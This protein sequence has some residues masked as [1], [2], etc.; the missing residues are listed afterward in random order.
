[1]VAVI[2]SGVLNDHVELTGQVSGDSIDIVN[3]P[4]AITD[5]DGHGTFVSGIIA[6]LKN[7]VGFHGIA[8]NSTIL[9]IRANDRTA[10]NPDVDDCGEPDGGCQ[11]NDNDL[12]A[13]VN[14]AIDNGA[15]IINLSLGGGKANNAALDAALARAVQAGIIL[16]ASAGN[17]FEDTDGDGQ[18]DDPGALSPD[19]PANFA[20]TAGALGRALAV[21]ATDQNNLIAS[22][23]NRAG[24]GNVRNFYLVAPGVDI[25]TS[26][27]DPDNPADR[28]TLFRVSGT[29]FSSPY[30]AG[31]LALLLEAF[32]NLEAEEAVALLIDTAQDL[33][34]VGVDNT[35]GAG[36]VDLEAAFAPV[37]AT[38]TSFKG[39]RVKIDLTDL[40]N[41][42]RGAFGDWA[43][44][45]GAF[46]DLVFQDKYRRNFNAGYVG[47]V[48]ALARGAGL[49]QSYADRQDDR[50]SSGVFNIDGFGTK[51]FANYSF[52]EDLDWRDHTLDS[53]LLGLA[54]QRT[55]SSDLEVNMHFGALH[56]GAGRG[57]SAP[58]SGSLGPSF[59]TNGGTAS[60]VGEPNWVYGGF[61]IS[62]NVTLGI[63]TNSGDN[64]TLN[65]F[66][67]ER[68]FGRHAL[69]GEI[70]FIA[71]KDRFF[72]ANLLSRFGENDGADTT[73]YAL[74]WQ[75]PVFG[76]WFGEG[77][78]ELAQGKFDAP[79]FI[80]VNEEPLSSSWAFSLRRS[81]FGRGT[82]NLSVSQPL[83]A[84][85]GS[86]TLGVP[87][88]FDTKTSQISY[89]DRILA[90]TPSGRELDIKGSFYMPLDYGFSLATWAQY[91]R[92]PQHFA[93]AKDEQIGWVSLRGRF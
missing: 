70:G 1:V 58:H 49:L 21:G 32:P 35:F 84:E 66:N 17:G 30:V 28:N 91:V 82:F 22:F 93:T 10:S 54:E 80:T 51:G 38:T 13:A 52:N 85:T 8:F 64:G 59:T 40:L 41:A 25:I 71:E 61:D 2:D 11:F 73:Y 6:G 45:G 53:N 87:V 3:Q 60:L 27:L 12:A 7:D 68:R 31:A 18:P 78:V 15:R 81:M 50:R 88:N 16:V 26:G 29:S 36:L 79:E 20:G 75:G 90:L 76:K 39:Q 83:R 63:V 67:L 69:V 77:R 14:Y 4:L 89:E 19:A 56:F 92:N 48:R 55:F 86:V 62:K 24:P 46:V 74:N 9:A 34:D 5:T 23:S 37:G 43:E 57:Y 42:Q 44:K 47:E 33:G 65:A 72:G